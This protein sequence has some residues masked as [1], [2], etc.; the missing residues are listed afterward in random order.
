[1][2]RMHTG[3]KAMIKAMN[4]SL[5]LRL[6][7]EQGPISRAALSKLCGLTPATISS[8]LVDLLNG[9]IVREIGSGESSGGRKPTMLELDAD[10]R[11]AIGVD[12]GTT[13]VQAALV[14]LRGAVSERV[15]LPFGSKKEP[16]EIVAVIAEAVACVERQVERHRLLGIGMGIHGLVD[17]ERGV[18]VYAPAFAWH[19]LALVE[20]FAQ[21]FGVPVRIDNDVRAMALGE[22]WCG[23]ARELHDFIM[24][25]VG[26]GVGSGIYM[27]GQLLRGA[28]YGAGEIGHVLMRN[29]GLP[30]FCGREGCLSTV[31]SGP[32]IEAA[33]RRALMQGTRSSLADMPLEAVDGAEIHQAALAGDALAIDVL[34]DAGQ[35]LGEALAMMVNVLNPQA[36]IVGGGVSRAGELVLG[37]LRVALQDRAMPTHTEDLRI[38]RTALGDDA[39][40]IGAAA[41]LL[42]PFFEEIMHIKENTQ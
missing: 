30:C 29:N 8:N 35:C 39:G 7:R 34:R 22:K 38:V 41:L 21:R 27:N 36:V 3:S 17:S 42:G 15:R 9:G 31:A 28:R 18:S 37:A 2:T 6:I 25:N 40:V 19:D 24:L 20:P 23:G 32:A 26:T 11:Y 10:A 16:Q 13:E 5:I 33:A 4:T 14:N 1:M 12:M